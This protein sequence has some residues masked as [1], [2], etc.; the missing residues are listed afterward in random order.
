MWEEA[1]GEKVDQIV[2]LI[3]GEDGSR[4]EYIRNKQDYIEE[5]HKVIESFNEWHNTKTG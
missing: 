4:E 3:T 1:T 2:V 5:L